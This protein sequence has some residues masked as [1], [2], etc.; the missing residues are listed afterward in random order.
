MIELFL[1]L[2]FTICLVIRVQGVNVNATGSSL[3]ANVYA[4]A[5]F[6]YQFKAGGDFVSYFSSGSTT[7]L[8]NIMG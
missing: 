3:A 6:A 4:R 1:L 7:G 2:L 5:T 8:C